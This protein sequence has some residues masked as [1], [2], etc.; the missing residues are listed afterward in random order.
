VVALADATL[1]LSWFGRGL[2]GEPQLG[3]AVTAGTEFRLP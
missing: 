1:G 3:L 2:G